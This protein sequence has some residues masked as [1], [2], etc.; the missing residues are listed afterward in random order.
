M[1]ASGYNG[2]PNLPKANTQ[3]NW[4]AEMINEYIKC[5]ADPVYFAE[6]YF[7]IVHVDKG[8][9]PFKLYEYQKE[10]IRLS[11][12]NRK[13]VMNASRQCGKTSV[14]T[15]IILHYALF[16]DSKKVALLA[17]KADTAQEILSRIQ[18]AYEYLPHWLKCGVS[19]WNK[20]R[21]EFDNGTII[22]AA[23]SSSSSIRGQSV[24]MLYIDECAFVERWEEFSAS[25]MPTLSSGKETRMIFTSTPCGLN[26][27]FHYVD[28][29][30]NGVNGFS[31][32]EV[33]WT[34]VPGRDLKWKEDILGTINHDLQKFEVEYNCVDYNTIVT[35]KDDE[36]ILNIAAGELF[37]IMNASSLDVKYN[38]YLTIRDMLM[39]KTGVVYKLTRTD[40]LAYIGISCQFEKRLHAHK[41]S[42]RFKSGILDAEILFEGSYEQ[43]IDLEESYIAEHDTFNNGLNSTYSGKGYNPDVENSPWITVGKRHTAKTKEKMKANHWSKS[44]V[45]TP[46]G[47]K[48]SDKSKQL[49]SSKRKGKLLYEPKFGKDI[50]NEIRNAYNDIVVTYDDAIKKCASKYLNIINTTNMFDGSIKLKSGHP[51]TE[52]SIKLDKLAKMYS[53]VMTKAHLNNIVKGKTLD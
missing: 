14:A 33:P 9:I 41:H 49:M 1:T 32:L 29:G 20:R 30:K 16:N 53:G 45:Y 18:L 38:E 12:L 40:G 11:S 39:N 43:C 34:A 31:V 52:H 10:A 25:V 24:S 6:T 51:L 48:H 28:G 46:K 37:Y 42:E 27:F 22:I 15:V 3:H 17:N 26:H 13:F 35:I 44:G 19:E 47:K 4:T 5:K 21:V 23:A 50:K 8:L 2:N 36:R 7:K